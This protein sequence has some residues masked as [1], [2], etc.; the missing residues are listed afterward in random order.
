M[1]DESEKR[2]R[3]KFL[4]SQFFTELSK[5]SFDIHAAMPEISPDT[6]FAFRRRELQRELAGRKLLYLD[7]NHWINLRHV[8]LKSP[9]EKAVYR[10]I[11]RILL[12]LRR[13]G[14]ICCPIS[15]L[16]FMELMKQSDPK[17]RLITAKL[18]DALS[19]GLCF[20]FPPEI[21]RIELRHFLLKSV[22]GREQELIPWV[23]T[24][25]GFLAGEVLPEEP[26]IPI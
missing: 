15:F 14:R 1:S 2:H 10:D 7:T 20:Q 21:G 12:K 3:P 17:T 19:E 26:D 11:L 24:K 18:M 6:Y 16:L 22:V 23:W 4:E 25:V 13:E 9:S 5:K 8:V